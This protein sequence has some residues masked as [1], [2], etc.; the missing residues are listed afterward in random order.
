MA[1]L[2]TVGNIEGERRC[3]EGNEGFLSDAGMRSNPPG[4]DD[5]AWQVLGFLQVSSR[6]LRVVG[7]CY[8]PTWCPAV[9]GGEG[10][11]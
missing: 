7:L 8:R 11:K 9:D 2:I 3:A 6:R 1:T 10:A 4:E 5:G